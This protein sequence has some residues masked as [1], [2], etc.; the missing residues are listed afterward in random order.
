MAN[1]RYELSQKV[2]N[3][4]SE[5]EGISNALTMFHSAYEDAKS[6]PSTDSLISVLWMMSQYIDRISADLS[7]VASAL[8]KA[9]FQGEENE[10]ET[11]QESK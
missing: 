2:E 10:T 7:E 9:R 6:Y 4:T 11:E 5:L 1:I 3:V 8:M